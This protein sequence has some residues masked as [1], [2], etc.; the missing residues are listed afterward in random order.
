M[1]GLAEFI[2]DEPNEHVYGG[3]E[4][5]EKDMDVDFDANNAAD[6]NDTL[7]EIVGVQVDKGFK[8]KGKSTDDDCGNVKSAKVPEVKNKLDKIN[9]RNSPRILFRVITQLTRKQKQD[10]RDIRFGAFLD[11]KIKD[12]LK[13]L[14]Y[15]LL[16][17]FDADTYSLNVNGRSI[18]TT[19]KMLVKKSDLR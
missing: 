7:D 12:V 6:T 19:Q 14:A 4:A 3:Q 15:W 2:N 17:K 9:L 16:E 11:F 8:G 18:M 10:I 1:L 13:R 5:S